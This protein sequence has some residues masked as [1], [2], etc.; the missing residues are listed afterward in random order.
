MEVY[1][2]TADKDPYTIHA[3]YCPHCPF[4]CSTKV[5]PSS[6]TPTSS[7]SVNLKRN[8]LSSSDQENVSKRTKTE[9][10][11]LE[12][13]FN[14]A[15]ETKLIQQIRRR[16]FSHWSY[17]TIPSSAQMIEAG[18]FNCN[19]GDR[20]I[21]LYCNLICQHWVPH[22][23]DPCEVHKALSPNCRYVKEKLVYYS[24]PSVRIINESTAE[25]TT[26]T[27]LST[28][29]GVQPL[30][31]NGIAYATAINS[32]YAELPKRRES[33][34]T[35]PCVNLPSVDDLVRAGFFY[36]KKGTV[37]ACFYC[38]G[39][40][41]NCGSNDNPMVEHARWCSHIVNML[42]S[43]VV[44]KCI[45][46]FKILNKF[47]KVHLNVLNLTIRILLLSFFSEPG[48][49]DTSRKNTDSGELLIKDENDLAAL[50]TDRLKITDVAQF[51]SST[52]QIC[53]C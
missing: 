24:P 13:L 20:L 14:D 30:I 8:A 42:N 36:T 9:T 48:D 51:I 32:I 11:R 4:I 1:N 16:T 17:R 27:P 29:S 26:N 40:L 5:S 15:F 18:F 35:W 7:T 19:V 46:K 25:V 50:V 34:G 31:C 12:S 47:N 10:V 38:N 44:M 2:W 23:D 28:S 41:Q 52:L 43:Y 21:C 45:G 22:T 49:H 3:E 39:S 53:C 37:V 33:F 6:D